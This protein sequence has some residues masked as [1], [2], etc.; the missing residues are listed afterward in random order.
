[1]AYL[2]YRSLEPY[3]RLLWKSYTAIEHSAYPR[4]GSTRGVRVAEN[5]KK[6]PKELLN[7][8]L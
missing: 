4:A 1:M 5:G 2:P 7:G 6:D 8:R 3:L